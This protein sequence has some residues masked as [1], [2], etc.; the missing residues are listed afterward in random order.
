MEAVRISFQ[1]GIIVDNMAKCIDASGRDRHT[2]DKA[3]KVGE[4][5]SWTVLMAGSNVEDVVHRFAGE[6]NVSIS[7]INILEVCVMLPEANCSS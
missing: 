7:H 4:L 1:I 2:D 3:D 6:S 5:P